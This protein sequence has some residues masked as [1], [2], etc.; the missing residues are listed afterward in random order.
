MPEADGTRF[1]FDVPVCVSPQFYGWVCGFDGKVEVTAPAEVR[2]GM[3]E[4][5]QK[6]AKIHQ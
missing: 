5:A 1:H 3:R 4:M 6:L 2:Q